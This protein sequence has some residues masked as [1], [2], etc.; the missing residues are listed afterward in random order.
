MK[1]T[2]VILHYLAVN[3]TNECINSILNNVFPYTEHEIEIIVVDNGSPNNSYEAIKNEFFHK[4][5][6]H[7]IHSSENLGFAKGNNLGFQYAKHK[8]HSDFI[9]LM[10][11]DTIIEQ[12]NFA[13]I[14][15]NKYKEKK[16]YVL[17]PDIITADGYH[18]NPGNKQS[19]SLNELKLFRFKKRMRLTLSYLHLDKLVTEAIKSVKEIY[20]TETLVGDVENTIL[21]GACLIFSPEY[22]RTFEGLYPGTFLYMEEDILKLYADYYN[23]LMLYSSDLQ[24]YHKEDVATNMVQIPDKEKVRRKYRLL[25]QSSK[26]YSD[27]KERMIKNIL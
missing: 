17:G 16:Y 7:L 1:I 21:H 14:I 12:S 10:N 9:I 26:M 2:F 4:E 22:V 11:N 18:Q 27:L 6:V 20:R 19:W 15:V 24:V 3:D 13:E 5:M 25:I 8:L 23:F